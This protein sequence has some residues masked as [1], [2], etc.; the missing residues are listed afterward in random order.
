MTREEFSVI[1]KGLKAIY[2]DPK[3]MPDKDSFDIWYEALKDLEYRIASMATQ[4]YIKIE[5]FTPVPADIRRYAEQIQSPLTDDMSEIE[6]WSMVRKALNN[7]Y[8]GAKEEFEKLPELI[9]E[10][11]G[12]YERLKEMSILDISQVE[13]VEASNFMRSYRAKLEAK[14]RQRQLDKNLSSQIMEIRKAVTPPQIEVTHETPMIEEHK[15]TDIP[16]DV[17]KEL[18]E[19]LGRR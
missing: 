11:L 8:Y 10:T 9:R 14:K 13:T 15:H 4:A 16:D 3:F 18:D 12:K 5:K 19:L 2:T 7:G 1:A 17:Q 6:A